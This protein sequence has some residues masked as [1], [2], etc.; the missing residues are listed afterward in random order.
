MDTQ[1]CNALVACTV[2]GMGLCAAGGGAHCYCNDTLWLPGHTPLYCST[3]PADGA[4]ALQFQALAHSDDAVVVMAQ[5]DDPAT[6]VGKVAAAAYS[7]A[8]SP[9]D[10]PCYVYNN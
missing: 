4:C 7:F 9:C 8:H 10:T 1:A 5:I 3:G 2:S 6:A